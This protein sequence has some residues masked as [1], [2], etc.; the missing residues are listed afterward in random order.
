MEN[1]K[2]SPQ[3]EN[4][5][6]KIANEL[7]EAMAKY[8]FNGSESRVLRIVIRKTYGWGKIK[9]IIPYSQI[10][11]ATNLDLRYVKRII[12]RLVK[13]NVIFKEQSPK[14]NILSLNKN[15]YSWKLWKTQVSSNKIDTG[16]VTAMS[17]EEG[18]DFIPRTV[19]EDAPSK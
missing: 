18:V 6:T 16:I 9:D 2:A 1:L 15:Y 7:L 8:P 3:L 17:L 5:Y 12:K 14:G 13:D 11:N 4:G 19:A 10:S